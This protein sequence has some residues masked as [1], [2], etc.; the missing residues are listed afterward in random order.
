MWVFRTVATTSQVPRQLAG[1]YAA[2]PPSISVR[3]PSSEV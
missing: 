2:S 3:T 1:K